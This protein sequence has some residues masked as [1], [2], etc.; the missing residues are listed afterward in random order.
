MVDTRLEVARAQGLDDGPMESAAQQ[1]PAHGG[2]FAQ[3]AGRLVCLSCLLHVAGM[4]VG[5]TTGMGVEPG[6]P[7]LWRHSLKTVD[8]C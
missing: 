6:V 4:K 1:P 7:V 5:R 3:R 2:L 8:T